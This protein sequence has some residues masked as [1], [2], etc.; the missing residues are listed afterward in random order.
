MMFVFL[1]Y[2]QYWIYEKIRVQHGVFSW[3]DEIL[4]NIANVVIKRFSYVGSG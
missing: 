2:C 4:S 1:N 3:D